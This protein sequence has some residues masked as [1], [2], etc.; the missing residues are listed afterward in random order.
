MIL[1]GIE[2]TDILTSKKFSVTT[3]WYGPDYPRPNEYN[4]FVFL[5]IF[6]PETKDIVT[7]YDDKSC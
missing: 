7:L 3:I 6:L 2:A 5:F 1:G 4:E